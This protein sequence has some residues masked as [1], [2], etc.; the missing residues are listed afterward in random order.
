[1]TINPIRPNP[2]PNEQASF[3][4][5]DPPISCGRSEAAHR[6]SSNRS[7]LRREATRG[8]IR[9][10]G[11]PAGSAFPAREGF[12]RC[13]RIDPGQGRQGARAPMEAWGGWRTRRAVTPWP[14]RME[15]LHVRSADPSDP[16]S[17][18][19]SDRAQAR[20]RTKRSGRCPLS[21]W[22]I[23]HDE[24]EGARRASVFKRSGKT[25]WGSA[26]R[27]WEIDRRSGSRVKFREGKQVLA[28]PD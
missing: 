22:C 21:V 12:M 7:R 8:A 25:N 1:V 15:R 27:P 17:Q 10:S 9:R 13:R 11:P 16:R 20:R 6:L 19:C 28:A 26:L 2:A 5:L 23:S 4:R 24:F 14:A 3:C 18:A